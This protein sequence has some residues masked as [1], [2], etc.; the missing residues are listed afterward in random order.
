MKKFSP[1]INTLFIAA[2]GIQMAI[3]QSGSQYSRAAVHNGNRVKTVFGNS[4]IIGAP[5]DTR[6]RGAWIY[7]TNGYIGDVSLLVGAEAKKD[8]LTFH[9]VVTCPVNFRPASSWD[10][11]DKSAGGTPWTFMPVA[12]YF[13]E[14]KQ[15]VAMSD[16]ESTWPLAWPDK[17]NDPLDPGWSGSW[18]GYFGKR[19]SANQE[20]YF[21]MDDNNDIR[22][23]FA[24]NNTVGGTGV[25]FKPDANNTARNGLGLEVRVRGMQWSQFLAQDNIFWLY[26][27]TNTGT[28]DYNRATFGMIVGTL[29]GVTGSQLFNEYDDDW[30]FYDVVE[31]ICYTGDFDRNVRT[32]NPFWQGN[33]GMVGYAFLESPGNPFDGIDNDG[34]ADKWVPAPQTPFFVPSNFDSV[35]LNPNQVIVLINEDFSRSTLTLPATPVKVK[36]RGAD[37]ILITPGTTKVSEGGL[38]VISGANEINPNAYDGVDNDFDGIIDENYY[39]HYRQVKTDPGP[40]V[41]TLIDILRPV[42]RVTY[43]PVSTAGPMTMVD[44]RR[45]DRIDNDLDWNINFDD[46]G[47]DG[48]SD[49][50]NPDFGEKDGLPTSGINANGTD[51]G[52]PGEPNIDKTDVDES[53][54]IGLTSFQY[55]TPS[56]DVPLGDDELMWN[57]MRPGFF[58]VPIS[59]VNNRPEYGQDGDFIYASAYFPLLA[60]KTE[61]FSLALVYGGGNGGSRED[62]ITD[63]L[64]HKRTVQKI[65]DANYQ[66]PI[67]PEPAP[68]LTAVPGD[69][70]V[71]LYW[72]RRSEDAVDPVLRIK[73]FQ[74]YKIYKASDNEFNDAYN[75]TDANGVKKGYKPSFQVD[76]KDSIDGYF[77]APIDIFDQAEGFTYKL[78]DNTGLVHDTT[79]YDVVNGRTYY[80]VIVA[81]DQGDENAGIFPSE[82]SWKIDINQ[83]GR[84]TGTSQNVAIVVPSR[85][86]IGYTPPSSSVQLNLQSSITG[87]GKAFY[88]VIDE[89]KLIA[90]NYE[91]TFQDTRD[92]GYFA[93]T[94]TTN[95]TVKDNSFYTGTVSPNRI[96]TIQ[97]SLPKPNMVRGSVT[98]TAG[99]GSL[100]DTAK[101][102]INYERGSIRAK[103]RFDLQPDTLNLK[104]YTVRY[105]YHPVYRSRYINGSPYVKETKDTDIFDGVQL[106]FANNWTVVVIDS[107]SGYNRKTQV[108]D[109]T[110]SL[111]NGTDVDG[112]GNPDKAN[113]SPSD[114]D[115]VFSNSV[116]DTTSGIFGLPRDP[117]KFRIFNRTENRFIEFVF[118]DFPP[119]GISAKDEIK[120]FEKD[121]NDSLRY[122]WTIFF[123]S[124]DSNFTMGDGDT[125]KIRLGKP[126]RN[127]DRFTF[128]TAKP[129]VA[130]APSPEELSKIRVVPNPYVVQSGN[131]NPPTPGTFSRGDRKIEFQNV[132]VGAKVSIYTVRGEHVKTEYHSGSMFNGTISWNL[133]TKENLDVAYGVYFYVIESSLGTKTGK[134]AIIK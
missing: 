120:F 105:Q 42:R 101:Y 11:N 49:P 29:V 9:S 19:A 58:S 40:P 68:V 22:F 32:R 78:G 6:P 127:G 47:R 48:V 36:T 130:S 2:F 121:A 12:G 80:Y 52:L 107:L 97:T 24:A 128:S 126:F 4:G 100:I 50:T 103:N 131:E 64:K 83:A 44:E 102:I 55:F 75:V 41:K 23:N 123:P 86:V 66:F 125:L 117:V 72:D 45:D 73:D 122:T 20:S 74:G 87:V 132:P 53:D 7:S 108:Y 119:S 98:L 13:N 28:E 89:S 109:Y 81:Y 56:N 70:Q 129:T 113:L 39:L 88:K 65:Y 124:P 91:V 99:D 134:L 112:D 61:R 106:S 3:A 94:A 69:K 77:R 63:L 31:N 93:A 76:L 118:I 96:D 18:N 26:E 37:S 43:T 116:V 114:Y 133:K 15:S 38:I 110:F 16:D 54:Q 62:D 84:I 60:K 34:D 25:S 90:T 111:D 17:M 59:I 46:V 71:K 30:S 82:N 57:R 10:T 51:S 79:D 115:V 95:Y 92:S 67:A 5:I 104:K 1:I 27:I 85:K 14:S 35:T 8:A 33:V 21:V